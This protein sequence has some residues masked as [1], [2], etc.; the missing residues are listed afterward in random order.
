MLMINIYYKYNVYMHYLLL[1]IDYCLTYDCP[2]I[3]PFDLR[4]PPEINTC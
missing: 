1:A 3:R 2:K 4:I